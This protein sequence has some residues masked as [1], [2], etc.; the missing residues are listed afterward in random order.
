MVQNEKAGMAALK[1]V[2]D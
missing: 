2:S 1:P